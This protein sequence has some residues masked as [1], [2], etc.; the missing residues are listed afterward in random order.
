M[1]IAKEIPPL[2]KPFG[3]NNARQ[4]GRIKVAQVSCSL[5]DVL[6]VSATGMR[7]MCKGAPPRE[8]SVVPVRIFGLLNPVDAQGRIVWARRVGWRRHEVGVVF[9]NL[10]A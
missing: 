3:G 4:K 7:I 10:S 8:S 6:D 1:G 9:E 5:G 2:F